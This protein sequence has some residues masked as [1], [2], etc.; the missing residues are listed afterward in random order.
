MFD[1]MHLMEYAYTALACSQL[2]RFGLIS[3]TDTTYIFGMKKMKCRLP[4][5]GLRTAL[6]N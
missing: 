1:A 6:T 5:C 4:R 3:Y 2:L